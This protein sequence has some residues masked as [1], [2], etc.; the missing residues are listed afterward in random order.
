MAS[1]FKLTMPQIIMLN[2]AAYVNREN[3][4]RRYKAKNANNKVTSDP[5]VA[6]EESKLDSMSPAELSHY[7]MD[8][9]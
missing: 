6:M 7:L 5:L 9:E 1:V 4:D 2:H 8:L 3:A